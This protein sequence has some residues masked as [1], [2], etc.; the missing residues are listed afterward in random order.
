MQEPQQHARTG[1]RNRMMSS[2]ISFGWEESNEQQQQQQA[3]PQRQQRTNPQP[4]GGNNYVDN[5]VAQPTGYNQ[6]R[7]QNGYGGG[8]GS[9]SSNSFANGSNQNCGNMITDRS[10]TRIH[11]PPGG[12]SSITFG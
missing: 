6:G 7:P 1:Y 2:N 12:V 9:T 5:T 10:S 3:P 11:A 8:V 4:V